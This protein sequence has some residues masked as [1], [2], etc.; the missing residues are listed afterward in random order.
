MA[1]FNSVWTVD[2]SNPLTYGSTEQGP[3]PASFPS[4]VCPERSLLVFILTSTFI[5]YLEI[6]MGESCVP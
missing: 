1:P 6:W 3:K 2:N 4:S 5:F